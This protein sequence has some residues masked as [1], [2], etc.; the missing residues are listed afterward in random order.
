MDILK[1]EYMAQ[2]QFLVDNYI[3]Y[4]ICISM[5]RMSEE[6]KECIFLW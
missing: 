4:G 2:E 3:W 6:H 1:E 5:G